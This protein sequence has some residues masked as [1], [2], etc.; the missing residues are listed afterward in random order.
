[1]LAA[2]AL[3]LSGC[4]GGSPTAT[5]ATTGSPAETLFVRNCAACH[6]LAAANAAGG[7]GADL[8]DVRPSKA[9]VLKAIAEGPGTMPSGLLKGADAASVASYVARVARQ[10]R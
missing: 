2:T 6:G 8:D 7:V 1:M 4:G 3:V 10:R 9:V 5:T